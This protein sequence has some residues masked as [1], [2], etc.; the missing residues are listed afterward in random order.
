VTLS[1]KFWVVRI[2]SKKRM[3]DLIGFDEAVAVCQWPVASVY[4]LTDG[5]IRPWG[6]EEFNQDEAPPV[7]RWTSTK[8]LA[9]PDLL[10]SFVRL[11]KASKGRVLR[12]VEK[13]G[14][15]WRLE[16][17]SALQLEN[18]SINQAPITL[19]SFCE[20]VRRVRDALTLCEALESDRLDVLRNRIS[21]SDNGAYSEVLV[22]GN[23]VPAIVKD[24][25][26]PAA[27]L[28][29]TD[30]RIFARAGLHRLIE[31]NIAS[32]HLGFHQSP[33][34]RRPR[35]SARIP[36]LATAIWYQLALFVCDARPTRVCP[37]CGTP[38]TQKRSDQTTCGTAAC[39]KAESRAK[40]KDQSAAN[41][42]PEGTQG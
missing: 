20:E 22:D 8:P 26:L 28:S 34:A 18:G 23:P 5:E 12:W 13:N 3:D 2:V 14:L 33:G 36:D 1:K 10:R 6:P 7:F 42:D 4:Y 30:V 21:L 31:A 40:K 39:R 38:Y 19:E 9:D 32:L 11:N 16:E 41:A 35:L 15:L 25:D 24:R 29:D 17:T 37:R 27:G